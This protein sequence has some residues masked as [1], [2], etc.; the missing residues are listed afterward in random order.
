MCAGQGRDVIPVLA[1]HP[2]RNDVQATLIELDERN[3]AAAEASAHDAG[4][5]GVRVVRGDASLTDNYAEYVPAEIVLACGIFGN[6]TDDDIHRTV[7]R[8]PSFCAPGATVLWTRGRWQ[9]HDVTVDIRRWFA[10]SGFDEIAFDAPADATYSVGAN[11][12]IAAPPPFERGI[13]M[14]TFFR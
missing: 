13:K 6:I 2:R 5:A 10:E 9:G 3:A 11:R 14:F 7:A 12:L 4:L 1:Q 8:L